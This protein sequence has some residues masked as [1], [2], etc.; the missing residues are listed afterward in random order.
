MV[1][2]LFLGEFVARFG[3]WTSHKAPSQ[4]SADRCNLAIILIAALILEAISV[5]FDIVVH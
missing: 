3:G 4:R 1:F 5:A 2:N